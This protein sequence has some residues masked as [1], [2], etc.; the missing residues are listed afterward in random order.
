M[1]ATFSVGSLRRAHQGDSEF[2]IRDSRFRIPSIEIVTLSGIRNLESRYPESLLGCA[3]RPRYL[4]PDAT[5]P[6]RPSRHHLFLRRY[7]LPT[8]GSRD[9]N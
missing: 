1:S 7:L 5:E 6:C 8:D 9:H 2:R 3:Q 4:F